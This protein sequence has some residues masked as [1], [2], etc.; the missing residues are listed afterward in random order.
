MI[1]Q[2]ITNLAKKRR[3]DN[4]TGFVIQT[5]FQ[6]IRKIY[7]K[8]HKTALIKY[9]LE[10]YEIKLPFQHDLPIIKR[11]YPFYDTQIGRIVKYINE[12]YHAFQIIDVGANVGDSA[13]ILKSNVDL[14][15]LCIE[16]DEYYFSLL[17]E[18]TKNLTDVVCDHSYVGESQSSDMKLVRYKGT[19]RLVEDDNSKEA[20]KF[21]SIEE[22]IKKYNEFNNIKFLKIDTD[23]FD[24]KIIRSSTEFLSEHKPIIFFEYDPH[25]LREFNDD[26]LSVFL[27]LIS[28]GYDKMVLY[29]NRG[30]LLLSTSLAQSHIIEELHLYFSGRNSEQYMD[31]CVFHN[32]DIDIFNIV[33][34][35]ELL[36]YKAHKNLNIV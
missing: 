24:C 34:K 7:L 32:F 2:V 6:V 22:I 5:F 26:G 11:H 12:K 31:I 20:I 14:P 1:A 10:K 15:I 8:I 18:N 4:L 17:L 9:K 36:Y 35:K 23:G 13:I 21:K 19:A 28:L 27:Y 29:D 3:K 25:L 30:D 16:A 33:R